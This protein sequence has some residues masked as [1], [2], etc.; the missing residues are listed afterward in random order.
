MDYPAGRDNTLAKVFLVIALI[1]ISVAAFMGYQI[2][3]ELQSERISYF[4]LLVM[5]MIFLGFSLF[6]LG[7]LAGSLYIMNNA[8]NVMITEDKITTVRSVF[9]KE[10]QQDIRI[11][12]IRE[13]EKKVTSQMGQGVQSKIY[14]SIY[15]H[16]ADGMKYKIGD[17]IP[18]Q[19]YADSIYNFISS[20]VTLSD[21]VT[22]LP[23]PGK[24]KIPYQIKYAIYAF[25]GIGYLIFMLTIAAFVLDFTDLGN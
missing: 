15:A 10:F 9:G 8:L 24:R 7:L 25:K 3:D 16:T 18:G 12:Q 2:Y 1:L 21:Q 20:K 17:G 4:A 11:G 23:K 19:R 13:L 5:S 22:A 6:G 14:Y